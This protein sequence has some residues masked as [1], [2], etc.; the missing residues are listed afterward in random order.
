MEDSGKGQ[1]QIALEPGWKKVLDPEINSVYFQGLKQFLKK[2]K[3]ERRTIY[4][5][6]KEIFSAFNHTPFDRVKVVILGQDPYHGPRQANGLCFSV[7]KGIQSP[8]S[9]K[10]I[11]KELNNDLGIQEPEHGDLTKWA[12]QGILLLNTVLTVRAREPNSHK[13]IGWEKF[14]GRVIQTISQE[15]E[16]MIFLL[17]GRKALNKQALID[18]DKHFIL[19]APHPSPFSANSGFFGCRHFSKTNEIL[20]STGK[21]P[22]DWQL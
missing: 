3:Q 5:P 8:P 7:H 15:K 12:G 2:E 17:W 4:P 16:G 21:K 9:L 20:R 6:G 19:T 18:V 1:N 11:F 14:T 10:N 13:N 22:I